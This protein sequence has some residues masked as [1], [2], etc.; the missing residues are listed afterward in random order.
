AREGRPPA[1]PEGTAPREGPEE[2]TVLL[3]KRQPTDRLGVEVEYED[4]RIIIRGF[5][6]SGMV[7]AWN[8][9]NPARQVGKGDSIVAV[10]G[11]RGEHA[12]LKEA[13]GQAQGEIELRVIRS[14]A[15][16]G[17][18]AEAPHPASVAPPP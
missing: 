4:T 12:R 9:R 13:L 11:V 15:A 1:E 10:N 17:R 5:S 16:G 2:L 3:Q 6:D 18:A 8:A 14:G 7:A